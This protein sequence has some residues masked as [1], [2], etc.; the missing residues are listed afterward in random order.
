MARIL[1]IAAPNI[2]PRG[3]VRD[4]PFFWLSDRHEGDV[5]FPTFGKE[6]VSDL[7]QEAGRFRYHYILSHHLPLLRAF[8]TVLFAVLLGL[9][10]NFT[11]RT[12]Y[13]LIISYG[14]NSPS[15]AAVV[16]KWFTGAK[17]VVEIQGSPKSAYLYGSEKLD[18][19][20]LRKRG[21]SL[22]L[23]KLVLRQVDAV[24]L[25]YPHQLDGFLK[26]TE[27]PIAV[28]HDFVPISSLRPSGADEK[29]ILLL[30]FP[31]YLKGA[32]LLIKAFHA[33]KEEFPD[34]R[35]RIVGHCPDRSLF[36]RLRGNDDRIEFLPG[37]PHEKAMKL[38]AS[39]SVFV[40]PSRTEGMARVLLEAM[41]LRKPIVA[42]RVDGIPHYI[43]HEENGLLFESENVDELA[44]QLRRVLGN[45]DL[46]RR[47]ADNGYRIVHEKY[48]EKCFAEAYDHLINAVLSDTSPNTCCDEASDRAIVPPAEDATCG[49]LA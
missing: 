10:H 27:M 3:D 23:L 44:A 35:L 24:K 20:L 14:W 43:K 42:S 11:H 39:C 7:M 30:G 47:L 28:F 13:D 6:Q 1:Y 26:N 18:A 49:S 31:W 38:M 21:W 46:A 45:P 19:R 29:F 41:A 33:I 37:T 17:V 25:L 9:R 36:E 5:I 16:L 12:R 22:W 40:L 32:D 4:V 2:A 34:Y 8:R 48:S 15:L